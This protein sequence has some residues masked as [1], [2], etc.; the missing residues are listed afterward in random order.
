MLSNKIYIKKTAYFVFSNKEIQNR[1]KQKH[2]KSLCICIDGLQA[3]MLNRGE[4]KV[5]NNII[6]CDHLCDR[7][8]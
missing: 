6:V 1:V 3:K 2:R 8:Q 7:N 4:K 5:Q